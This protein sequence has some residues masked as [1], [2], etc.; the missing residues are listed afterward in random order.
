MSTEKTITLRDG[1]IV[2]IS[3][4]PMNE[5]V[6]FDSRQ[7]HLDPDFLTRLART[8][9]S[10]TE[11]EINALLTVEITRVGVEILLLTFLSA[12]KLFLDHRP[13]NN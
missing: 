9:S 10:L 6:E 13:L 8:H 2:T 7:S 11:G 1:R 12:V 3:P 4:M 5:V